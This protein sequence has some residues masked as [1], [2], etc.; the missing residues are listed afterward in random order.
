MPVKDKTP[1]E[2]FRRYVSP[3]VD[4]WQIQKRRVPP[5]VV[6]EGIPTATGT[7]FPGSEEIVP[8]FVCTVGKNGYGLQSNV[9]G[10]ESYTN[11][12][13][14]EM[15]PIV[16]GAPNYKRWE[17]ALNVT[18]KTKEAEML[19]EQILELFRGKVERVDGD[20]AHVTLVDS[21]GQE[22][23]AD[24]DVA[25]VQSHGI[26]LR[27]GTRF[28]GTIKRRNNETVV[29]F[30]PIPRRRLSDEEWQ[31]LRQETIEALG[32]YDPRDDY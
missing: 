3:E 13:P 22:A 29:T 20:V 8:A 26:S 31:R 18:V 24:W 5:K 12:K 4:F 19:E 1:S 7:A 2:L 25:K 16:Q 27:E 6:M 28:T 32:D 11:S 15:V 14:Y 17:E 21:K 10:K 23:Y 30:E 9:E